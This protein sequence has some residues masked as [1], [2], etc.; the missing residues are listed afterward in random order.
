MANNEV[1]RQ[2]AATNDDEIDLLQL[3]AVLLD[4]KWWIVVITGIVT[5][6]GV[7][8]ALIATP[9]YQADALL[10][11]ESKQSGIPLLGDAAELFGAGSKAQTEIE[12]ARS[13]LVLTRAIEQVKADIRVSPKAR[14][15]KERFLP[16]LL[17]D[18]NQIPFAGWADEELTLWVEELSVPAWLLDTPLT[19]VVKSENS[20]AL[21]HEGRELLSG[22]VGEEVSNDDLA[23]SIHVRQL[24]ASEGAEFTIT[25]LPMANLI[26]NVR[27]ALGISEKGKDS[28][29]LNF[30]YTGANRQAI[31][32][33]LDAITTNYFLQNIQRRAEEAE[34]SL[35]FLQEQLPKV[36]EKL[37]KAEQSL[38]AHRL[39]TESVDLTMEAKALLDQ[40]VQVEARMNDLSIKES[41]VSA[42]FTTEHPTYRTLRA[43]RKSLEKERERLQQEVKNMPENQQDILRLMRDVELNQ[44]IYLQLQNRDQELQ[45]LKAGTVGN[46][47]IIDDA[48]VQAGRVKPK[49]A[50]IVLISGM[51]G[52]MLA[53]G[54]ALAKAMLKRGVQSAEE[55]EQVGISVYASLPLSEESIKQERIYERQKRRHGEARE[56][57]RLLALTHPG[58]QAIE[59]LRSLRTSLYFAMMDASNKVISLSGPSPAVG[60]SF[61]SSNLAVVLAQAGQKVLLVDADLRKGR[62]HQYFGKHSDDKGL[63]G[64]LAGRYSL[65]EV[66][67]TTEVE[68]LNVITR[69]QIP[70]NP[71]ELLMQPTLQ[72]MMEVASEE[73]DIV[74]ID[75]PPILAVTDAAIVGQQ[76]GTNLIVTRYGM[77]TVKE[78]EQTIDR[79]AKNNVEIKGTILNAIER[80]ASNAYYYYAYEYSSED[81]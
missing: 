41:E 38:S 31:A 11:V 64:Y 13:R 60:K 73:Y 69:G 46:V 45:I 48:Q 28:G 78:V 32:T 42:L 35:E 24:K 44:Q 37:T 59:A 9:I 33:L 16:G 62:L 7:I 15:F 56:H 34:K 29:I 8:Y 61:V 19:F 5:F 54:T 26:Q 71:S 75:T 25:K 10:Q 72:K 3:L 21:L 58:D 53:V 77:S 36:H 63:S 55:L 6:L 40:L 67:Q 20:F 12:I 74:L 39:E 14:S 27:S 80:T 65:E 30:T 49:R 18:S 43:Q 4:H 70:P 22:V 50:L 79:F 51:L 52:G 47:R 76:V 81:K 23:L 2:G 57:K 66:T 17:A 1:T 68:G